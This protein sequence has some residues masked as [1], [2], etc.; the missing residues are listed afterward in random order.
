M[1]LAKT[2]ANIAKNPLFLTKNSKKISFLWAKV[3]KYKTA[4][5]LYFSPSTLAIHSGLPILLYGIILFCLSS[6]HHPP[7]RKHPKGARR[8]LIID[9]FQIPHK[10]KM[11]E[12][13]NFREKQQYVCLSILR[14]GQPIFFINLSPAF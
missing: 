3:E 2:S 12:C 1:F 11:G 13:L 4:V 9:I 14:Q 5:S 10:V 7:F 8:N 6:A